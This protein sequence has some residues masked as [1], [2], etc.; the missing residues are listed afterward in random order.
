M[1]KQYSIEDLISLRAKEVK[2]DILPHNPEIVE[3]FRRGS[4]S[5]ESHPKPNNATKQKG[6]SSE[7]S[8]EILFKGNKGRR[9]NREAGREATTR[10]AAPRQPPVHDAVPVRETARELVR[11]E[12][13]CEASR[14]SSQHSTVWKYRGRSDSE[15][16]TAEPLPAPT[17]VPSQKQEG[18][19]KFFK[20]VISP[21]HVRVTAG[22]RIVPNTRAPA[23]PSRPT[24]GASPM[25]PQAV[26]DQAQPNPSMP[27]VGMHQPIAVWPQMI[28]GYPN[29]QGMSMIPMQFSP[30]FTPGY[31]FPSIIGQP[32][33]PQ[34]SVLQPA[35]PQPVMSRVPTSHST[36]D[37][38]PRDVPSTTSVEPHGENAT[39]NEPQ[40]QIRITPPENFDRTRPFYI[41][42]QLVYPVTSPFPGSVGNQFMPVQ[43]VG[44]PSGV[45]HN[46]APGMTTQFPGSV[47]QVSSH[48]TGQMVAGPLPSAHTFPGVPAV[49]SRNVSVNGAPGTAPPA[50]S[51]KMSEVTK[52]Q[53][54]VLKSSIK[55][56]ED[57]LQ[58]NRFQIDE[59]N[60]RETLRKFEAE[61]QLF[62]ARYQAEV[63]EEEASARKA[64]GGTHV[65]V[66]SGQ[67]SAMPSVNPKGAPHSAQNLAPA[68]TTTANPPVSAQ[69]AKAQKADLANTQWTPVFDDKSIS[70]SDMERRACLSVDAARA[71]PFL[72]RADPS[73]LT[74]HSLES[75]EAA[76]EEYFGR[77]SRHQSRGSANGRLQIPYL[78]GALPTGVN[79]RT[80][81]DQDYVY[82]RP[83][84]DDELRAR[85]LYW[86]KA[87][88]AVMQG[89]PK[90]DGKHF[91]PP[92]PVKED[93]TVSEDAEANYRPPSSRRPLHYDVRGTKSDLDPFRPTTP[94]QTYESSRAMFASE[95]GYA[96]G[97]HARTTSME[98]EIYIPSEKSSKECSTETAAGCSAAGVE[99]PNEAPNESEC[100][101]TSVS[102]GEKRSEKGAIWPM[103]KKSSTS[104]AVSSTTA[105]G[106]LPQYVGYAAASLS[107]SMV[108]QMTSP[109]RETM[110][111]KPFNIADNIDGIPPHLSP[112]AEKRGENLPPVSPITAVE[113]RLKRMSLESPRRHD[114]GAAFHV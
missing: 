35:V 113:E 75:R 96:L 57:Q 64:A 9:A 10:Q 20:A 34:P 49:Q 66:N 65:D 23:S 17:G 93:A 80:A 2:G 72:P 18:F 78:L 81:Q 102:I 108:R 60:M 56:C 50:S 15:A 76:K 61:R 53:I 37:G 28:S 21:T 71:P 51:I 54:G 33:M 100:A 94:T 86:G 88:K 85:Y 12:P 104:S 58:Y 91:Y 98:T 101:S 3:I 89:L 42:G 90:F 22:G 40:D 112:V 83:L 69:P 11:G 25:D 30:H 109:A 16:G 26:R 13:T 7:S 36:P 14:D 47:T 105:Q 73:E 41:N 32:M 19:Q 48:G 67:S 103:L 27:P 99:A 8:D 68:Q 31:S 43:M 6:D 44:L 63:A 24:R 45:S 111:G 52:K 77:R 38:A 4:G 106:Y 110:A 70:E 82:T 55:W 62:E 97:R 46:T 87:P 92:S 1:G 79:P 74:E 39:T 5:A 59:N 114:V 29:L 84:T 107:P 95:D